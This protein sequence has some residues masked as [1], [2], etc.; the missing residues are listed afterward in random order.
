MR[1]P[2]HHQSNPSTPVIVGIGEIL[3][4]MLPS[5]KRAGG[6]PVNFAVHAGLSGAN[7][8]IISALGDDQLGQQLRQ[9]LARMP[10]IPLLPQTPYP[11]GQVTVTLQDGLPQYVIH[12]GV[13]WDYIPLTPEMLQVVGTADGLCLGTLGLRNQTSKQ[14]ILRLLDQARADAIRLLDLNLRQSYYDRTLIETLLDRCNA[15][16]VNDEELVILQ[17]MF[18]L[19]DNTRQAAEELIGRFDLALFIQTAGADFSEVYHQGVWSHLLTPTVEVNDT[20]GAGDCFSGTLV[21]ALLQ[22]RSLIAAHQLAVKKAGE[23]CK[24]SGAWTD[25]RFHS[26]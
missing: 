19:P 9:E 7:S 3:W 2:A 11:T 21:S 17:A 23:I 24:I 22:G 20:I 25:S 18:A 4:D 15:L 6:A 5:E 10:V 16:K 8:Y 26:R 12:E 14:T 1:T 13:A